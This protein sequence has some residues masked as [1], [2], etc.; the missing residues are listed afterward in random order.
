MAPVVL[1]LAVAAFFFLRK[2]KSNAA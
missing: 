2:R 1:V